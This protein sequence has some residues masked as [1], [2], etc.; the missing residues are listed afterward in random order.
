VQGFEDDGRPLIDQIAEH[1][2]RQTR[3]GREGEPSADCRYDDAG[4]F[5]ALPGRRAPVVETVERWECADECPVRRLGAQ[6]EP[7]GG[8]G[9]IKKTTGA[10][11]GSVYGRAKGRDA[12]TPHDRGGRVDRYFPQLAWSEEDFF[13]LIY[14]PK[15]KRRLLD[16]A[17]DCPH[18]TIK[19]EALI[20]HL[21]RLTSRP[22]HIVLD[23]WVGSGTA[24]VA[25]VREGRRVIGIEVN[26]TDEEPYV[27][28]AK[29]RALV[30]LG[31]P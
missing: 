13:P 17:P 6:R 16:D 21:I 8:Y 28:I 1:S 3:N 10:R 7:D 30:A 19:P 31:E 2:R 4:G 25:G 22:G 5:A 11:N 14:V 27:R 24:V 9:S 15:V 12:W 18:P 29:A 26:D 20:R 23:P